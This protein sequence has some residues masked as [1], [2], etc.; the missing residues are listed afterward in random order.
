MWKRYLNLAASL[1]LFGLL[2]F[3]VPLTFAQI[4]LPGLLVCLTG[5]A[6]AALGAVIVGRRLGVACGFITSGAIN[7][8][9]AAGW[10]RLAL[11]ITARL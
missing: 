3:T 4:T 11:F 1:V 7:L 10:I 5:F 9:T 8:L 6:L 2:G